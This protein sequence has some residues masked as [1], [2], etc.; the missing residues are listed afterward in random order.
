MTLNLDSVQA[1]MLA[2]VRVV[3]FL[4]VAP[5]FSAT[6]IPAKVKVALSMG[7]A[8][9]VAPRLT[10]V[11]VDT[12]GTFIGALVLQA[13]AGLAMGF[14]VHLVFAAVQAAGSMIDLFGGFSMAQAYDPTSQ[15]NGAQFARLY[16]MLA[17]V[18]LFASDGYQVVLSGLARSFDALPLNAGPDLT[19]LGEALADGFPT[20]FVSAVQ[21]AGP[22]IVVLFLT[23]VGLGL[24]TRAA[25]A[26]N[27]FALGFPLKVLMTLTF[28]GFAVAGMLVLVQG[29]A[30]DSVSQMWRV[31][32]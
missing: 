20:M 32:P 1:V 25:P 29:L 24:L 6:T 17:T 12:T 9:A 5:P 4:V 27:A 26:L 3:G 8:I 10:S 28:A 22:L 30:D 7:M 18:L 2:A 21:I 11:G 19:A 16:Q 23:D 31:L 13:V 15:T 14:L